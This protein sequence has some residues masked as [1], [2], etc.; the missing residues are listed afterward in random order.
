MASKENPFPLGERYA[1]RRCGEFILP[2]LYGQFPEFSDQQRALLSSTLRRMQ[3]DNAPPPEVSQN[4]LPNP[5]DPLPS[6]AEQ[7]DRLIIW[8]GD[9]QP[10]HEQAIGIPDAEVSAWIG[11]SIT[12]K[13]SGLDWLLGQPQMKRWFQ[14]DAALGRPD[15]LSL[16]FEG[17]QRYEELKRAEVASHTAFMA[18]KFDDDMDYVVKN[19]FKPAVARTGF[20]L[21]VLTETQPAGLIDDQIR[22][23]LRT[24]RFVIADLTHASSGAY[25]EAGFA[26]GLGRPVIYTCRKMEWDERKTHFDTSHMQHII[27]DPN[28]LEDAAT[29]LT[30]MIRATLLSACISPEPRFLLNENA[31]RMSKRRLTV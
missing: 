9:H 31:A 2:D 3:R 23:A 16:T 17:W 8:F 30:A 1:C 28:N 20:E 18:M 25:W 4:L 22:V 12:R 26:E 24:S 15:R 7:A 21:R 14:S 6:P 10:S 11:T 29:P 27:W 13:N 5:E 19:C